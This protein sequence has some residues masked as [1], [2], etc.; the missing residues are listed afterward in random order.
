METT[1]TTQEVNL[2]SPDV[3]VM[4]TR[5]FDQSWETERELLERERER[6]CRAHGPQRRKNRRDGKKKKMSERRVNTQ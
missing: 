2:L 6:T 3:I 1:T 4:F 5:P